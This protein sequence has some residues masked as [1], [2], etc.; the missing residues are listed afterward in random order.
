MNKELLGFDI[1]L[2]FEEYAELIWGKKRRDI[3]LLSP[4]IKWPL[5]VDEMVWPSFFRYIGAGDYEAPYFRVNGAIEIKP[6]D[7]RQEALGLWSRLDEMKACFLRREENLERRGIS[8]AVEL[9]S[10][11]KT[12]EAD[13]YWSAVLNPHLSVSEIPNDWQFLGYDVADRYMLS[14]LS[15]CGYSVD[16]KVALQEQWSYRLNEY[17]L[18]MSLEDAIEFKN[19]T[20]ERVPEHTPF[21]IYSLIRE[22]FGLVP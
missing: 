17:G 9:L 6:R 10:D 15:N 8:I 20:N 2:C 7:F 22:P 13:D 1:R 14:G 3:H 16:E 12:L 19:L 5:S 11:F 18:L 21:Y 4:E